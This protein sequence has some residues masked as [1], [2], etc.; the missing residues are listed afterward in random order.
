M[1]LA[2]SFTLLFL[3]VAPAF[4][5][6][7]DRP[8][9]LLVDRVERKRRQLEAKKAEVD[10]GYAAQIDSLRAQANAIQRSSDGFGNFERSNLYNQISQLSSERSQ[11]VSQITREIYSLSNNARWQQQSNYGR[12]THAYGHDIPNWATAWRFVDGRMEFQPIA[13][14]SVLRERR[15]ALRPAY[16]ALRDSAQKEFNDS[17]VDKFKLNWIDDWM[18][19]VEARL[20]GFRKDSEGAIATIKEP[21]IKTRVSRAY[22]PLLDEIDTGVKDFRRTLDRELIVRRKHSEKNIPALLEECIEAGYTTEDARVEISYLNADETARQ[23]GV[24]NQLYKSWSDGRNGKGGLKGKWDS[25]AAVKDQ[26]AAE[27]RRFA[28]YA[29]AKEKIRAWQASAFERFMGLS[30]PGYRDAEVAHDGWK[31]EQEYLLAREEHPHVRDVVAGR[32]ATEKNYRDDFFGS[33]RRKLDAEDARQ[34]RMAEAWLDKVDESFDN[35][36][37]SLEV[38]MDQLRAEYERSATEW[39]ERFVPWGS[40]WNSAEGAKATMDKFAGV[41][42]YISEERAKYPLRYQLPDCEYVYE[43]R[44]EG[45]L[46]V[47]L[48]V[49]ADKSETPVAHIEGRQSFACSKDSVVLLAANYILEKGTAEQSTLE[50]LAAAS[51]EPR[52]FLVRN[53]NLLQIVSTPDALLKMAKAVVGDD[54]AFLVQFQDPQSEWVD[55]FAIRWDTAVQGTRLVDIDHISVQNEVWQ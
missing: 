36:A 11:A 4:A 44:L 39:G 29:K 37:T 42:T 38:L 47:L 25:F 15:R 13:P 40:Q 46:N 43:V 7:E 41:E 54:G 18:V 22:N 26:I 31:K 14:E 51:N 9:K 20:D 10:A 5:E 30:L 19:S 49:N 2:V 35:G 3:A 48:R 6:D 23:S 33:L 28:P 53:N 17:K 12:T 27:E 16:D 45:A 21:I 52:A 55:E 34:K 24:E 32:Y 1:R 50:G 8:K